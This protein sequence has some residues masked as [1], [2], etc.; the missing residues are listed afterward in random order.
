VGTG[1][2]R[3]LTTAS[4]V[5]LLTAVTVLE[6]SSPASASGE[7]S[8]SLDSSGATLAK[9]FAEGWL[10][11]AVVN[12]PVK[13]SGGIATGSNGAVKISENIFYGGKTAKSG[14]IFLTAVAASQYPADYWKL[15][16]HST[17][18]KHSTFNGLLV[19]STTSKASA[20]AMSEI[21]GFIVTANGQK[22]TAA[23]MVK[24]V[25]RL[26]YVS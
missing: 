22:Q 7:P 4:V 5:V 15:Y 9:P 13:A 16:S 2:L 25:E 11:S 3:N 1:R 12:T 24:F 20:F 10:P 6:G 26:K 21:K 19:I 18:F 8:R 14:T 17:G 23:T